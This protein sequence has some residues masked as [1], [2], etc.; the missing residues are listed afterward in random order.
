M[1][2]EIRK[3][4]PQLSISQSTRDMLNPQTPAEKKKMKLLD[5]PSQTEIQLRCFVMTL[6]S[7][8]SYEKKNKKKTTNVAQLKQVC[9]E[10]L[11]K[12]HSN[13][14]DSLPVQF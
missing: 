7:V 8:F 9:K 13:V 2:Q 5:W 4:N 6:M 12:I 11:A 10:E 1:C 3:K 14:K